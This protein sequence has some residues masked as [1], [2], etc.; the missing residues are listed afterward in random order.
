MYYQ[1]KILK[2]EGKSQRAIA[3]ILGINRRTVAKYIKMKESE[4]H[5]YIRNKGKKGRKAHVE[6]S[7]TKGRYPSSRSKSEGDPR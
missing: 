5:A 3:R 7:I 2:T 1:I 4:A 6:N